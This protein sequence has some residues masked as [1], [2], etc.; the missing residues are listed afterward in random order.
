M[1]K[2]TFILASALLAM[3]SIYIGQRLRPAVAP[4]IIRM[5]VRLWVWL[6]FAIIR[7]LQLRD[8]KNG[9][10]IAITYHLR[11]FTIYDENVIYLN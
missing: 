4:L 1:F 10:T 8:D 3:S 2:P 11:G 9:L 5:R 6:L 7:T